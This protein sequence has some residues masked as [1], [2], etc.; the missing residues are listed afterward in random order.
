VLNGLLDAAAQRQKHPHPTLCSFL[1]IPLAAAAL[2]AAAPASSV[3]DA[4]AG[5]SGVPRSS[6]VTSA[7]DDSDSDEDDYN[8]DDDENNPQDENKGSRA[9]ASSHPGGELNE[10]GDDGTKKLPPKMEWPDYPILVRCSEDVPM[11]IDLPGVSAYGAL[12]INNAAQPIPFETNLFKGVAMIRIADISTTDHSY[13]DGKRRKMQVCVQGKFKK[14]L[15]FDQV[16]GGQEFSGG[17]Q[18]IPGKWM[19]KWAFELLKP[20]LPK[21]FQADLFGPS[22]YFLS[23]LVLTAQ[24]M[25]ADHPDDGPPQCVS[26]HDI[27]E[28][29]GHLLGPDYR[30]KNSDKGRKKAFGG[31]NALAMAHFDTNVTYTFDYFQQF[32]RSDQFA[33]DLGVKLLDLNHY[34]GHQPILLTMAKTMDTGEYLWKFELWHERCVPSDTTKPAGF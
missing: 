30:G 11:T 14:P 7:S 23:P 24:K 6:N 19:I 1:N 5:A 8:S 29:M 10:A 16:F 2:A 12:P 34:L 17:L 20:G 28:E 31:A 26:D 18:N 27:A 22:P 25:R 21:S 4:A 9:G 3:G 33:L 15:R 32:L 13:F